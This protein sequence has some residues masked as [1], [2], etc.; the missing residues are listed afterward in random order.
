MSKPFLISYSLLSEYLECPRKCYYNH[1]SSISGKIDY[2]R[3]FGIEMHRHI[4][5]FYRP[6]KEARVFYFKSKKS[7]IGSWLNRWKRALEKAK[8]ERRLIF[9]DTEKEKEYARIGIFCVADYWEKNFY[10][11]R[12]LAVEKRHTIMLDTGIALQG[13]F[14]QVRKVSRDWI[15]HHRPELI[16]DGQ[17]DR[18]FDDNVIV[19]LKTNYLS[20]DTHHLIRTQYELHE[21]LQATVFTF[22]YERV[23]GKKPIGFL[24]YHLRSGKVF[25]TYRDE[26]DYQ[27]L[28]GIIEHVLDNIRTQSFPKHVSNHCTRCS[29]LEACRED[30]EFLVVKPEDI[31]HNL[32]AVKFI[33]NVVK[34]EKQKQLRF[35][36]FPRRRKKKKPLLVRKENIVL[37]NLPWD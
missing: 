17:L 22:L 23:F 30:R 7:A 12:P 31:S 16:K 14:D 2:S 18:R 26:R 32:L 36:S 33:P 9:V 34:K 8:Q 3:L 28:A 19:D 13:V 20:Y 15:I 6:G 27:T 21:G 25:F 4:A 5:Q 1:F 11:P 10:A 35:K 29:Y 24:W 37:R